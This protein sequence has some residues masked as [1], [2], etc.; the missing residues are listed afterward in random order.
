MK[1]LKSIIG[2]TGFIRKDIFK[3]KISSFIEVINDRS[4]DVVNFFRVLQ[5]HYYPF[6]DLLEFQVSSR[7]A[8]ERLRTQD[9][10]TLTDLERV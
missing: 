9:P 3:E 4:G 5:R 6:M 1:A 2:F 7:E 8:F 10:K